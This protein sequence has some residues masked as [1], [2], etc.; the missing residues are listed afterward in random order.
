MEDRIFQRNREAEPR[1]ADRAFARRIGAPEPVEDFVDIRPGH[2][3]SVV[4]HGNRDRG[5]VTVDRDHY[6]APLAVLDRVAEEVAQYAADAAT[7]DIRLEIPTRSHDHK[8]APVP[9]SKRPDRVDRV[10]HETHEV[11]RLHI[12]VHGTR[13]VTTDF[14]QI[15]EQQ[16]EPLHLRVQQLCG[17]L[18]GGREALALVVEQVAGKP[19]GRERRAQLM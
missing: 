9:P 7:V 10:F 5:R 2:P 18:G 6:R 11:R 14:E 4:T 17:A 8:V 19:D 12:E 3:D 16:L 1:A 13:I 15:G